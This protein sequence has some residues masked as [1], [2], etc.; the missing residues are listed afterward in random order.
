MRLILLGTAAGGGFPQWNCACGRCSRSRAGTEAMRR[1]QD[2]AAVSVDG[3]NWW[4]LNASPDLPTQLVATPELWPGPGRRQI[5]LRGVLLTDAELDHTLGLFSLRECGG[6]PVHAPAA[7]LA[8]LD[9]PTPSA[10]ALGLRPVLDAYGDWR[11]NEAA[12][13]VASELGQ[14]LT[15]T[16]VAISEKRPR[17][18]TGVRDAGPSVVAYRLRDR[19]A[20]RELLYAPCLSRWPDRLD[21]AVAAADCAVL[22]GTFYSGDELGHATGLPGGG[23][24]SGMGHLPVGGEDG[25]LDRLRCHPGTRRMYTHLNNTNPLVDPASAEFAAVVASGVEVPSDGDRIDL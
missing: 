24:Q 13:G 20:G 12:E 10:G 5:P 1:G 21:E 2:G 4:L 25:T 6:L 9:R 7:V 11:W 19:S 15:A 18:R 23:G 14:G 3:E 8:S 16:P 22:D 17:Y